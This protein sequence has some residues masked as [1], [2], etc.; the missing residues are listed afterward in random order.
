M[1]NVVLCRRSSIVLL[2]WNN[3]I[4]IITIINMYVVRIMFIFDEYIG[5]SY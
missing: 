4:S 3:F 1:R 2:F 5:P